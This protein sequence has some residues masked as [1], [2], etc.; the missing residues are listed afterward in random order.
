MTNV[1]DVRIVDGRTPEERDRPFLPG[2][3]KAW[4]LPAYDVFTRLAGVAALHGRTAQLAG[5][6]PG[7]TVV[8]VGCGTANLSFAVLAGQPDARVTGLDPD[9]DAL[10]RAARKA[11]RCGMSLTLVQGY[12]DRI[13]A[14]DAALDHVVSSIALHHVDEAGRAGFARDAFRALRPGGRVT[15]A[16][17]GGPAAADHA[18]H[19]HDSAHHTGHGG[20]PGHLL[21]HLS[22]LLR[23]LLL[24]SRAARSSTLDRNLGGGLVSLLADAGF[25]GAREVDHLEH[26]FGRVTFVQATRP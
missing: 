13:P 1:S 4:L 8:D 11:R 6:A 26:A 9:R 18:H 12:A 19:D 7:Q 25:D 22:R 3:G 15:I 10:S 5:V 16:D 14:G 17:F 2:M 23:S 20:G 21:A 24:R